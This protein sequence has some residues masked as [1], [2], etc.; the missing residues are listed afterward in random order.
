MNRLKVCFVLLS[1]FVALYTLM[2]FNHLA[3]L[4]TFEQKSLMHLRQSTPIPRITKPFVIIE[5]NHQQPSELKRSS[6]LMDETNQ[7]SSSSSS[8]SSSLLH[9]VAY[10]PQPEDRS[11][12]PPRLVVDNVTTTVNC[13]VRSSSLRRSKKIAQGATKA[14]HSLYTSFLYE[15]TQT[16]YDF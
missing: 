13:D 1:V 6:S 3:I 8:S 2:S 4:R 11:L 5:P 9:K 15:T 12:V 16:F 7:S 14:G 10:K